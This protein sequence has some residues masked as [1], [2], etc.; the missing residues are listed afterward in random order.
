MQ[1]QEGN[2]KILTDPKYIDMMKY[3]YKLNGGTWEKGNLGAVRNPENQ[4]E[5]EWNDVLFFATDKEIMLCEGTTDPGKNATLTHRKGANHV[6]EGYYPG[7]WTI[8]Y[9]KKFGMEIF[10]QKG[11]VRTW[12]DVNKNFEYDPGDTITEAGPEHGIL[13][14]ST[15]KIDLSR[16]GDS[17]WACQVWRYWREF[18]QVVEAARKTGQKEFGYMLM[19]LKEENKEFYDRIWS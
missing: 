1:L 10:W 2:M 15:K 6:I 8:G 7:L 19:R 13:G 17:S 9:S 12:D 16:I 3:A 18:M 14:H 4:K 5:D 11:K